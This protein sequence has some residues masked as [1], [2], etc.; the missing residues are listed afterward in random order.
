M[1]LKYKFNVLEAL[2]DKGYSSYRL[3]TERILANCTIQRLRNGK[4]LNADNMAT[5]CRL[6]EVQPGEL[7]YYEEENA[8]EKGI[9]IEH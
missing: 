1:P 4:M 2:K 7:L 6:L 5:L 8:N 3:S 9:A